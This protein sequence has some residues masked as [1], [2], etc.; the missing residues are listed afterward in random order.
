MAVA[1]MAGRVAALSLLFALMMASAYP[2]A[3]SPLDDGEEQSEGPRAA[4][5][6]FE[7]SSI[8]FSSTGKQL[9]SWE[10][11]DGS[12][13]EYIVRHQSLTIDV[14]ITQIGIGAQGQYADYYVNV[15]HQMQP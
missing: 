3:V 15:T 10:Q 14:T 7:V 11:P 4:I 9:P 12:F 8:E 13:S 6:D 2:L 1:D 5:T